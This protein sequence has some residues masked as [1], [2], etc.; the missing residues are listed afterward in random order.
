MELLEAKGTLGEEAVKDVFRIWDKGKEKLGYG[1]IFDPTT[2][3]ARIVAADKALLKPVRWY[4]IRPMWRYEETKAGRYREFWQAGAE[5]I[6]TGDPAADAEILALTW[7]CLKAMGIKDFIFKVSSRRAAEALAD[8]AGIP[9]DK[10]SAAFRAMDKIEKFGEAA[11]KEE[12]E[13]AGVPTKAIIK[14]LS[15]ITMDTEKIRKELKDAQAIKEVE[16]VIEY[17]KKMGITNVKLDLSIIRGIDYYTGFVFETTVKGYEKLGSVA[18]GGRYDSL[19]QIYGGAPTPATGVGI[20][21]DRMME[22]ISEKISAAAKVFVINVKDEQRDDAIKITQIL[23][24]AG[25]SAEFNVSG[26]DLR[27]Q[28]EYANARGIRFAVVIGPEEAKEGTVKVKDMA[29]G[30]EEKVKADKLNDFFLKNIGH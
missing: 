1:L 10:R 21:I 3:I 4:Y 29:T 19:I 15:L 27:K 5:L 22:I 13:K 18:S 20:G 17:A 26:K 25:I 14:L 7:D 2:P 28:F 24:R 23:R 6:G 16:Q 12:M 11:V 9:K 8:S 30:K